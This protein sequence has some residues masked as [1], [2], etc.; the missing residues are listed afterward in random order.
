MFEIGKLGRI[1]LGYQGENKARTIEIDMTAW[2]E[3]FPGS[4]VG[5]MVKRPNEDTFYPA[6]IVRDGNII[7][8]NI[9]RADV[10]IPGEGEAQV[11]LTN[12]EDVELRCRVVATR[13]CTSMSGTE[14]DAPPPENTF[15]SQVINAAAQAEAAVSKMPYIGAN[16]NW[17][18]WSTNRFVDTG[19][20][21][22]GDDG[23]SVSVQSVTLSNL[24]GGDNIEIF[25]DGKVLRVKNG[26]QGTSVSV[27]TVTESNASGGTS[28]VTFTDGKSVNIKNGKDGTSVSVAHT[29]ESTVS[30]GTNTITFSDGKTISVKNGKDGKNGENGITPVAGQDYWTEEDKASIV[31]DVLASLPVYNGEVADA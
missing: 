13:I 17:Y 29:S 23:T 25:T 18:V 2:L 16:G 12:A 30:G 6:G 5:I 20:E 9:T 28:T 11:I 8:W 14:V 10:S 7:S 21:S 15:V 24:D 1:D 4:A 22:R 19:Y 26:T 31:A 3:D 27:K